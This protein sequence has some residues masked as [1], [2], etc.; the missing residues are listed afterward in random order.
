VGC[1]GHLFLPLDTNEQLQLSP[2]VVAG[3]AGLVINALN[4]IP[5]GDLDG[6]RIAFGIWGRRYT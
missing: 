3:W 4:C 2:L 5:I 1:L 6:G